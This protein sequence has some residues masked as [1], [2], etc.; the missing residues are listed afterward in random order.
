MFRH[1]SN[2][3]SKYIWELG[4]ISVIIKVALYPNIFY[5]IES[6]YFQRLST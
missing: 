6:S 4:I 3:I 1:V 5:K 2:I